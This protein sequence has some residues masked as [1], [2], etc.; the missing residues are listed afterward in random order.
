MVWWSAAMSDATS[1]LEE[2]KQ[3]SSAGK[4][5]LFV[6]IREFE[7]FGLPSLIAKVDRK[8]AVPTVGRVVDYQLGKGLQIVLAAFRAGTGD[9][10]ADEIKGAPCE[11]SAFAG[12][13]EGTLG[14]I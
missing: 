3:F 14:F 13:K 9:V 10:D 5:N 6:L 4:L 7:K 11:I 8:P 2:L 12:D 1:D